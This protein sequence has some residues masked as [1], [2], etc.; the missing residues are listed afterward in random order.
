ME[1]FRT[2]EYSLTN[3]PIGD[4]EV[5]VRASLTDGSRA[6]EKFMVSIAGGVMQ[7]NLDLHSEE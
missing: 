1:S 4:A 5:S 3:L 2:G 6:T 7:Y